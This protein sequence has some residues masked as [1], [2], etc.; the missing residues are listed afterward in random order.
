MQ[1]EAVFPCELITYNRVFDGIVIAFWFRHSVFYTFSGV[2]R[3]RFEQYKF[4]FSRRHKLTLH[5]PHKPDFM[6]YGIE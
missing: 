2:W 5:D 6:C 4:K 3:G 1:T